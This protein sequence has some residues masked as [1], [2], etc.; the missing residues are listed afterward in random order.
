MKI[1]KPLLSAV[2]AILLLAT[3][4]AAAPP[5]VTLNLSPDA[6]NPAS[7][8][9]GD[10]LR[11]WSTITNNGKAPIQ[12]LVAWVSLVEVDQGNEQPMDL[13][14]WSAHKAVAGATLEPGRPLRTD[15]PMRLIKSGD[16]R[17]I[18]SVT[19]RGGNRVYTS[20]T[21]QFHV[22]PKPM[23][24]AGRVTAVAM[25]V[26]VSLLALFFVLKRRQRARHG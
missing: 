19:D 23:L 21:I 2:A 24:K 8:I 16:Y 1:R 11:F 9:M 20:P 15:W 13:E 7:P 10:H 26:P 6:A 5:P 22:R 14:D 4:A 17:V 18:V 3:A 25:G 12:G